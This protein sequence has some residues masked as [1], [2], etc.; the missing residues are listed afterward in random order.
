MYIVLVNIYVKEGLVEPFIK[1]TKDNAQ[2]SMKEPG[3]ARFD[4]FQL[5]EDPHKFTL[6]EFYRTEEDAAAHKKTS[7]YLKW[8]DDVA[9]MMAEPRNSV[10]YVD[11]YPKY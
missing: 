11:V 10:K 6:T 7:H 4:L 1:A 8:R 9:E 3:I 2:N 5:L